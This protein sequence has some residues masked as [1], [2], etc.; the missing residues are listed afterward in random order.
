MRQPRKNFSDLCDATQL[1]YLSSMGTG[2][3]GRKHCFFAG[4]YILSG[5]GDMHGVLGPKCLLPISTHKTTFV[6][7]L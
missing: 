1:V 6:R 5:Q 2:S 7:F 3:V 4:G